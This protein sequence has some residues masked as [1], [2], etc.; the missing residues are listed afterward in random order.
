[1]DDVAGDDPELQVGAE[2]S[3]NVNEINNYVTFSYLSGCWTNK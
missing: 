2:N 1:M 3:I